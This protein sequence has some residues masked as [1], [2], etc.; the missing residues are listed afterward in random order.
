MRHSPTSPAPPAFRGS[1]LRAKAAGRPAHPF[2]QRSSETPLTVAHEVVARA[3]VLVTIALLLAA[4]WSVVA[5]RASGGARDHRFA[6][7]RLI[8]VTVGA[9]TANALVGALLLAGGG[10]PADP[11]HLLYGVASVVT[12]PLGWMLGG[13]ATGRAVPRRRRDTWVAVAAAVLLGIELRLF[14][15]G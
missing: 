5:A 9:T 2:V 14:T 11:L 1:I 8:L 12:A 6:V 15:T 3:I 4:V 13:R 10:R 7:D